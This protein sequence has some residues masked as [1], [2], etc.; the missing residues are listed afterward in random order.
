MK[1][2]VAVLT[3]LL[4]LWCAGVVA[5]LAQIQIARHDDYV[6][7]AARQQ[8]RTLELV[9][10][11]GSILD[12]RG[13]VL[14]ES[15]AG[16][17][18]YADPQTITDPAAVARALAS[19]EGLGVARRDLEKRLGGRGEFAWVARQLP[20][21]VGEKVRALAIPGI[22]FLE[23][24]RRSYPKNRLAAN[25][26]GY[27]SIDG[28]G[29]GGIEHSL[30]GRIRGRAGKVTILRDARRGMYLVGGEGAS[31]SVDGHDLVLTIDEV[32]QF[33]AEKALAKAVDAWDAP[34]G[35]VVVL[36]PRDGAIL[37]LASWPTFDPNRFR[38][39]PPASWRNRPVQDLYEP[40]STFK[41]VTAAAAIEERVATP[42]QMIDCGDGSIQI[43]NVRIREHDGKRY[44]IIPFDEVIAHSSN[45]GTIR[46]AL[47]LGQKR[48]Y[49]WTRRFGFGS[50][51]G[52]EL[53]GE[54]SGIL[55]TPDRW[56]LLSNAVISI[57]QEIAVTPLQVAAA[58][59]AIANGGILVQP[60][61]VKHVVDRSGAIV[62]SAPATRGERIMSDRTAAVLNE[63]LKGVVIRGTGKSAQLVEYVAAGKTGTAQKAVR[64]GYHPEKT[65]A[66]FAGYVPADRP[67]LVILVV[68]DEPRGGAYGGEVAGPAFREIAEAALRYLDIPPSIPRREIQLQPA[69]RLAAFS[70]PPEGI[71]P[72]GGAG[73]S[74]SAAAVPDLIGL[75]A[76]RAVAVATR[77]GFEVRAR[78]RGRVTAQDP[79]PGEPAEAPRSIELTMA[80]LEEPNP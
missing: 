42:S 70:Q 1:R 3:V 63:M 18:V 33:A 57:G 52:V 27:V 20:P 80:S 24:S 60:H 4:G 74:A 73:Q 12:A 44:G 49:E 55:R 22:Y 9:A 38:S 40:G 67:R 31:G 69:P 6:K 41:I 23:E 16:T 2:R 78:G 72:E 58:T 36:D 79:L 34:A 53:P 21:E 77:A 59:A 48:F 30:D 39:F 8:E 26:L 56:S 61:V 11:R 32:I 54:A 29:L 62:S 47:A 66:S 13:R 51:T 50:R 68:V 37:A 64:G 75:D 76:R 7:R 28:E 19:V 17:S 25:I 5:R 71:V 14:A 35:S 43:A 10:V 45:V 65:V 15:V 46:V